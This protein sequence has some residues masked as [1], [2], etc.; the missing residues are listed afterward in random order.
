VT[1]FPREGES[2][3]DRELVRRARAGSRQALTDLILRYQSKVVQWAARIVRSADDARDVSQEVFLRVFRSLPEYRG[4]SEF[5]TWVWRITFN[6]S[7]NWRERI[8]GRF[9]P[10][11][12]EAEAALPDP[13]PGPEELLRAARRSEAVRAAVLRLPAHFQVVVV[14]YYFRGLTYEQTA[15]ALKVPVNTVK[16]HLSRAKARLRRELDRADDRGRHG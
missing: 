3:G 15:G 10:L 13:G 6:L 7:L 11:G 1:P 14:L 16:T 9:L 8:M 2:P 12:E 4:E 5:S